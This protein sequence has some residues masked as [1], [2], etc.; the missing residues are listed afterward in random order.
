MA[1]TRLMLRGVIAAAT[2]M[3][4]DGWPMLGFIFMLDPSDPTTEPRDS[5]PVPTAGSREQASLNQCGA[6]KPRFSRVALPDYANF[7]TAAG[8][9][10]IGATI[11][12]S[13]RAGT[14]LSMKIWPF[15]G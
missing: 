13:P 6:A 1:G 12:P 11:R 3:I 10:M 7:R 8:N 9:E 4:V 14:V 5:C 2:L 15:A